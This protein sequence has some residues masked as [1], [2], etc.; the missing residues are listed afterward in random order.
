MDAVT[1]S[2]GNTVAI[3]RPGLGY[4]FDNE[5]FLGIVMIAPAMIYVLA[6]VGYPLILAFVYSFSDI[7]VGSSH[8]NFVGWENFKNIIDDPDFHIALKNTLLFTFIS[9]SIVA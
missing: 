5:R 8:F 1:K 3:Q 6:L 2:V 9:M 7:T 4:L